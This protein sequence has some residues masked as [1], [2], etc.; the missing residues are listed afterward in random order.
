LLAAALA[1]GAVGLAMGAY[2]SGR[3]LERMLGGA[4]E[5]VL[6]H[7]TLPRLLMH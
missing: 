6:G 7:A 4:T 3:M 1:A 2:R 5:H